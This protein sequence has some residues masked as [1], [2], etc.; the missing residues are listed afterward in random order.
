[1]PDEAA[2]V[3]ALEAIGQVRRFPGWLE[4]EPPRFEVVSDS[5]VEIGIDG[6]TLMMTPPLVFTVRPGALRVRIPRT[7]PGRSPASE[8][9]HLTTL[10]TVGDLFAIAAGPP[11]PWAAPCRAPPLAPPPSPRRAAP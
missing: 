6:E 1:G 9:L 3:V 5:P 4:W 7:A 11:L 2:R 10:S 8:A